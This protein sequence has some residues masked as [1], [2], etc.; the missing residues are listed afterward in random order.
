MAWLTP[1]ICRAP[2][3]VPPQPGKHPSPADPCTRVPWSLEG[4]WS[5]GT[6][7]KWTKRRAQAGAQPVARG[8]G[9]GWPR[10]EGQTSG[11]DSRDRQQVSRCG[12]P[13]SAEAVP[14]TPLGR[15]VSGPNDNAARTERLGEVLP[16]E[17]GRTPAGQR[18]EGEL[19]VLFSLPQGWRPGRAGRGG[20]GSE[21]SPP[22]TTQEVGGA[23]RAA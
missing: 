17:G 2:C 15:Q 13:T 9:G 20:P 14:P 8:K 11:T 4:A 1:E 16:A 22:R 19:R 7:P 10:E 23:R 5:T 3:Q 18:A 21:Q 6:P 12:D